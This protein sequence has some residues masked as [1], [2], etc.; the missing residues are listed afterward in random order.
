MT[1][2]VDVNHAPYVIDTTARKNPRSQEEDELSLLKYK[3]MN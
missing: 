3:K 1:K 2:R